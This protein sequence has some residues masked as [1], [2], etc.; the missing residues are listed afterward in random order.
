MHD[1]DR[2]EPRTPLRLFMNAAADAEVLEGPI[3]GREYRDILPL[4]TESIAVHEPGTGRGAVR[5][6][7]STGGEGWLMASVCVR[8]LN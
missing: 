1:Q 5:T 6:R 3:G 2:R 4:H 7:F 8:L